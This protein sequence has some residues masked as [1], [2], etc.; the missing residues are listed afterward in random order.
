MGFYYNYEKK[1]Q[2]ICFHNNHMKR[3]SVTI[4][5]LIELGDNQTNLMPLKLFTVKSEPSSL[6]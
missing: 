3:K 2:N 5:Y 6:A 4:S 1:F